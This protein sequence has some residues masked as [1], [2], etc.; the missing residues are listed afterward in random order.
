[1][2]VGYID[3]SGREVRIGETL[4][5]S[6][7]AYGYNAW[8]SHNGLGLGLFGPL[9]PVKKA[10]SESAVRA[11]SDMIAVGDEFVRSRNQALDGLMSRE[12]T[13]GPATYYGSVSV[14]SSKTPPKKQPGFKAHHGRANRAFVDGHLELEDL[15]LPF[16]A[17]DAQLKRWN[18]DNEPH[19]E[20]LND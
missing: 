11:P 4:V 10:A 9:W 15:R 18:I 3:A 5:P 8:G 6:F 7:T 20:L 12:G 19:P 17:S 16:V 2:P 13:I 14:Y 1:M